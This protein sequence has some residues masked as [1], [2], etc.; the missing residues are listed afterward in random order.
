MT[1]KFLWGLIKVV[2]TSENS[3]DGTPQQ[4]ICQVVA[5]CDFGPY[6]NPD[7]GPHM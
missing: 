3:E 7:P 6:K 4:Q 5:L 1:Y 2:K